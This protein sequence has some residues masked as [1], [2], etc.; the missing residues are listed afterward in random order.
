MAHI[1]EKIDFTAGVFIVYN[2]RIFLRKHDKYGFWLYPGG[3]IELDEDPVQA[4]LKEVK[5]ETGL[6]IDLWDGNQHMKWKDDS[7]TELIPPVALN[8][9][10]I[11]DTHEH[12]NLLYFARARTDSVR[13]AEGEQQDGW[14]WCSKDDLETMDLRPDILFYAKLALDTIAAWTPKP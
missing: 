9:H 1:H 12:V 10:H 3:H 6:E 8:R 13:P 14:K 2:N 7:G 11:T 4:A 5:E